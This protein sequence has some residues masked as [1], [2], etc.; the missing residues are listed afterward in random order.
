MCVPHARASVVVC[1]CPNMH[2]FR[3]PYVSNPLL[4]GLHR[5]DVTLNGKQSFAAVLLILELLAGNIALYS[6]SLLTNICESDNKEAAFN[7]MVIHGK[8]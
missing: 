4:S 5:S 6:S 7:E 1:L 3:V 2:A 8:Y